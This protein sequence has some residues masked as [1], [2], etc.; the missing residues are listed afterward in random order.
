MRVCLF[1]DRSVAG[2]EP[3]TLTRPAFDLLCGCTSLADKQL[4]AFAPRETGALVRPHLAA[5]TQQ[6]RASWH[7]NDLA[8]LRS[9]PVVLVNARWMPDRGVELPSSACVGLVGE[10]VAYAVLTPAELLECSPFT[11]DHYLDRWRN[12]LPAFRAGGR[13]VRHLWDLV[14]HNGDA[15]R[16]DMKWHSI[17]RIAKTDGLPTVIGPPDALHAC[18]SAR[19]TIGERGV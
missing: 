1:E 15:I 19:E 10:E 4:R 5:L 17:A 16:D 12:T 6:L 13:I 9:G 7:I 3:L 11:I 8:W 2:L 14:E 18:G